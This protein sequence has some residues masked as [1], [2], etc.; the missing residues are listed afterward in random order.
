M[1]TMN[2]CGCGCENWGVLSFEA[3]HWP[4]RTHAHEG[5]PVGYGMSFLVKQDV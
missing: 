3:T 1:T 4:S 5:V 2:M